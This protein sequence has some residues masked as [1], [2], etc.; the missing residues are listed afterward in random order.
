MKLAVFLDT[1][2]GGRPYNQDRLALAYTEECVLLVLADGMGGHLQGEVA[3]EIVVN[4]LASRFYQQARPQILRPNRF[5]V[6]TITQANQAIIN[7][8]MDNRLPEVPSTTLVAGILQNDMLY[9]CHVG[10]SRLYMFDDNG[11]LLRSR[12]HSQIQ[13]L[14]EQGFIREESAKNHPDRNK[15][16]NCLGAIGDPEVEIGYKMPMKAGASLMLCSDGVWSQFEDVELEKAFTGRNVAQVMPIIMR[17]AEKRGGSGGDN[18]SSVALTLL[19]DE[20]A[21]S[22]NHQVLDTASPPD[23]QPTNVRTNPTLEAVF[24]EIQ[25]SVPEEES[26]SG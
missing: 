15:I 25:M 14:I 9:W 11:I 6:N 20:M 21:Q 7:Y 24:N 16:Y 2:V 1:R 22:L 10:D 5:L 4:L 26:K 23:E 18:L 13:R 19:S 17:I 3:A 8:A 12:D